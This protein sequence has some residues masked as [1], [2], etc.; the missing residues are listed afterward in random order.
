M[1][2]TIEIDSAAAGNMRV[3]DSTPAPAAPSGA[4]EMAVGAVSSQQLMATSAGSAP[5]RPEANSVATPGAPA[6]SPGGAFDAAT[7]AG[8]APQ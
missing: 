1:R 4:A 8:A 3:V 6:V 5:T 2:I 7:S